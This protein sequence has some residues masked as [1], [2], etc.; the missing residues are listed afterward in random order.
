M[1]KEIL[2]KLEKAGEP[3]LAIQIAAINDRIDNDAK[4][5]E[6][7]KEA[8]KTGKDRELQQQRDNALLVLKFSDL[9]ALAKEIDKVWDVQLENSSPLHDKLKATIKKVDEFWGPRG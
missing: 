2:E 6:E 5:I 1:L 8:V 3:L 7:L 9:R 4:R